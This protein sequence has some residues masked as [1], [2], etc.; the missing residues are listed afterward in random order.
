[1][2]NSTIIMVHHILFKVEIAQEQITPYPAQA[3]MNNLKIILDIRTP[4][5]IL[6]EAL[7]VQRVVPLK[8]NTYLAQVN[9]ILEITT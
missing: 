8:E 1:M 2:I 6:V 7:I 5:L 9:T 3:N 4:L